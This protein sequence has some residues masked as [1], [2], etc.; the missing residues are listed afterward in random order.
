[1][2]NMRGKITLTPTLPGAGDLFRSIVTSEARVRPFYTGTG[3][4]LLQPSL[5]GY[6]VL[7]VAEGEGSILEPGYLASEG[8]V[9]LGLYREPS[10]ESLRRRRILRRGRQR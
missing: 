1:M 4:I 9:E 8:G 6:H 2:S 3:S 7:T 10:V 5:G